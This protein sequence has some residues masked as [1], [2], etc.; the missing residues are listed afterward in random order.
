MIVCGG[1][2]YVGFFSFLSEEK[3][4]GARE[5][6]HRITIKIM[7]SQIRDICKGYSDRITSSEESFAKT[8]KKK[9]KQRLI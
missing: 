1:M 2:C 7:D 3:G 4:K 5:A 6:L 8:K 9:K